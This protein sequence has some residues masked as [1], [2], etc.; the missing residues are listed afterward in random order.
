MR[1][2][3]GL[4]DVSRYPDIILHVDSFITRI[5]LCGNYFASGIASKV[6]LL[7]AGPRARS[8]AVKAG[9]GHLGSKLACGHLNDACGKELPPDIVESAKPS[10]ERTTEVDCG[11]V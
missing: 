2:S 7:E 8:G 11:C 1:C 10:K 5:L 9:T 6:S 4:A 3:I